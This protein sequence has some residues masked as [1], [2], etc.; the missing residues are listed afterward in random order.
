MSIALLLR[1]VRPWLIDGG[2][3]VGLSAVAVGTVL[4]GV[5][6]GFRGTAPVA[7]SAIVAGVAPLPLVL[8]RRRPLLVLLLIVLL[9]G[10]PQLLADVD[11]PFI[12][13]LVVVVVAYGACAQYAKRPWNWLSILLP[14]ALYGLYAALDPAF[15]QPSEWIFEAILYAIGWALGTVFRVLAART[16]ALASELLAVQ[17]TE[18]MRQAALIAAE[19]E[20]IARELHDVIARSVTAMVVQAGAARLHLATDPATSASALQTVESTGREALTELRRALGLLRA[21]A[22]PASAAE[23]AAEPLPLA[24]PG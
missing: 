6:D 17:Q 9:R 14:A 16:A 8:R 4:L 5:D 1:R 20:H 13:G 18:A 23:S 10:V 7:V 19:R 15:R 11:R 21:E 3:A 22:Q 12:G 24:R 2:M